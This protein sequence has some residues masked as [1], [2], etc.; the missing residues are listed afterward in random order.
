MKCN[1]CD[2]PLVGKGINATVEDMENEIIEGLK[3]FSD[4]KKA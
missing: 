1:F 2:V 4:I 3:L